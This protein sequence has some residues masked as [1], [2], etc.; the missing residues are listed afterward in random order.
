MPKVRAN[1]VLLSYEQQGQGEPLILIPYL[2]ADH[3]FYA[4][5]LADYS[6]HFTCIALD[7]RGTGESEGPDE[8]HSTENLAADVAGF[9]QELGIERAHIF[10]LSLGAAV[11]MWV[12]A[13]HPQKVKSLSLHSAWPKSD[14]YL[15]TV[16][17]GWQTAAKS[18][19]SVADMV[20]ESI[21]PWCF[22]PELYADKPDHIEALAN[23]VRGRP[24]QSLG[25]FLH[26]S[27]AVIAHDALSHLHEIAAP[28]QVTFGKHD[29]VTSTRF[30]QSLTSAI[31]QSELTV[32]DRCA[33]APIYEDIETF[34]AC[35]LSFLKGRCG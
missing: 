13:T 29:M 18:L 30:A 22:T 31:S 27:N 11:G 24:H 1:G 14:P 4:F 21:F 6:K 2:A 7:L 32:F 15:K 34:N 16:V 5:Q 8:P 9:M 20:V 23:F 12:A 33:H 19:P 25:A 10:G 26:Q 17:R 28:T 35:T 3:A